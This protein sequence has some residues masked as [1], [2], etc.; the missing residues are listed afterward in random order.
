MPGAPVVTG[1]ERTRAAIVGIG[2]TDY[3][4]HSGRSEWE[5]ANEAIGRAL[6]DAGVETGDV[7]GLV[8]STYDSV[9]EAMVL[10]SFGMNISFHS[11]IGY[12]GLGVPGMVAHA[13]AAIA[14]G[15]ARVVVAYRS[16]NGYSTIR[17]GRAERSLGDQ[18]DVVAKGDR[19]PSGAFAGPY[20]ILSP[21]HVM[22]LWARRYQASY[23]LTDGQTDEA[24]CRIAVEQRSYA[25]RNPYAVMHDKLLGRD[26]YFEGRMI[27][28]PLRLYDFALETDG[29]AAIVVASADVARTATAPPAY[30]AGSITGLMPYAESLATYGELRNGPTYV[31]V[32]DE[33]YRRAGM[34]PR[35][36]SVGMLYDA[37][38]MTVLLAYEAYGLAPVGQGWR[39]IAE[40]GIGPDAPVPVNTSGG[41][42][43]EAY[44]HF[45]NM[46]VEGVRQ[47][48][49][50]STSQVD[51]VKAVLCC[52]GPS[53][54]ILT[55]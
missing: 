55:P 33:L 41:H 53:A 43:S 35:D 47:C 31:A 15:Q 30:I 28:E 29:A 5:L 51:D 2:Q 1:T 40:H 38:V 16:L 39:A 24:F 42:L 20:G 45:M 8:H 34:R 22:A 14:S 7:D 52:S 21:G 25:N 11:Q 44:V 26:Q 23:G 36:V 12:G 49:G 13:Q 6:A 46:I 3:S 37:T 10:R 54:F 18:E 50:T 19:V 4:R 17:Y 9:D 27:V 32:A 48:R